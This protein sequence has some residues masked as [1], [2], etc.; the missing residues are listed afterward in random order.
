[1]QMKKF[2]K[3]MKQAQEMQEKLETEMGELRVEAS[4][5]G[6]VVSVTMDGKK[7]MLSITI[8]PETVDSEEV[9]MLQDLV[10]A[11]VNEA[12]RKVDDTL[13]TRMGGL[14]QGLMG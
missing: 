10:L 3:L 6:G 8:D 11:A 14:T 7:Q 2:Q 4:S 1:M 5:G 9:E 13:S 12:V